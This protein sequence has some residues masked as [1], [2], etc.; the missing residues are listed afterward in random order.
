M[1]T[2]T[3]WRRIS[4][5]PDPAVAALL[6]ALALLP[7]LWTSRGQVSADTKTYLT[8]DP[9]D[10]LASASSMWDPSV[11]AGTVPHQNIG[12][13]FPLGPYYWLLDAIGSPD[14]LA[15]RLLWGVLVF[16]ASYGTYRLLRWLGWAPTGS[17]VAAVAYGFSPYLLSYLAR[18]SAILFPWAALPWMVLLA[19]QAARDH[20]WRRAAQF[21]VVV[22]LVGSVNATSL[23]FVGL[24]PVLWLIAD[25][26][27]GRIATRAVAAAA[28]RIGVLSAAVSVWWVSGLRVQGIY[29]LPILDFTE[30]YQTVASASTA[31]EVLRGLG[32]WFFYGGDVLDPWVGPA[33]P[34]FNDP[35]VMFLSFGLAGCALLGLLTPFRGRA[36]MLLLFGVGLVL[37]VGAAPLGDSTWY[38]SWFQHFATESTAGAALRSTPRAAPLVLLALACGL[39]AGTTALQR[40]MASGAIPALRRCA[41]ALPAVATIAVLVN[42]LP[43][44]T[45]NVT[46]AAL[47]RPEELPAS[48]TELADYVNRSDGPTGRIYAIPGS[49]FADYQWGGTVDPVLPGLTDRSVLYRELIPQGGPGT[50]DLLNAFERRLFEGWFE[51]ATL[52]TIAHLFAVDTIVVRNDLQHERYRL[53][54]PG[55]LWT[56][57]TAVLGEADYDGVLVEDRSSAALTDEIAL[58]R[59]DAATSFPINAA[60]DVQTGDALM[61]R[62]ASTPMI[63]AGSGDGLVDLA[64]AGLLDPSSAVLYAAAL[65]NAALAAAESPWW[66][67]TDTNR[68]QAHRWSTLGFNLGAIESVSALQSDDDPGDSRLELFDD[69]LVD[70][71]IAVH[72]GDVADVSATSYGSDIVYITEDAPQFGADGDLSTA[73]RGAIAAPSTGLGYHVEFA[74]AELLSHLTLV[75]PQVGVNDRFITR[76]RV[77]TAAG[78]FDVDLTEDSR[79]SQG[80]RIDV[81]GQP[82]RT[83]KVSIEILAD[84]IGDIATYVGQPGVGFAEVTPVRTDGAPVID[85]RVVRL[86]VAS[87]RGIQ[88]DDRLTYVFTRQRFDPA[89]SNRQA[90]ERALDR[91]FDVTSSRSFEMIGQAR[92]SSNASDAVLATL[93]TTNSENTAITAIASTRLPGSV[94][95]RGAAAVDGDTATAWQTPFDGAEGAALTLSQ[96]AG[97]DFDELTLSWWDDGRH[98]VPTSITVTDAIDDDVTVSVPA[99]APVDGVA[100]TT[101]QLPPQSGDDVVITISGVSAAT[102]PDF[103]SGVPRQLP[104]AIAE[105]QFGGNGAAPPLATEVSTGCR[106]DLLALDGSALSVEIS[107]AVDGVLTLAGCDG[108]LDLAPGDHRLTATRGALTGVDIDR[109]VFDDAETGSGSDPIQQSTLPSVGISSRAATAI[110][111]TLPATTAATWLVLSQS[112]NLGWTLA[113]DGQDMGEPQLINGYAN[114]WLLDAG[115]DGR[116]VELRWTPQQ[117]VNIALW[118]S[119]AAGVGILGLLAVTARRRRADADPDEATDPDGSQ[120]ATVPLGRTAQRFIGVGLVA[121]FLVVGGYAAGVAAAAVVLTRHIR[122]LDRWSGRAATALVCV[123]WG[124]VSGLI[125]ASEWRYDYAGG[126]DWPLQF[127]WAS[128]ITWAVVATVVTA[129]MMSVIAAHRRSPPF[130]KAPAR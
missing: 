92:L 107:G 7:M 36:S 121:G 24:A 65:D 39:G 61:L 84:N 29:G 19:A 108:P 60:F 94:A 91:Q 12:Y 120:T 15:Q 115:V 47:L 102:V 114:G 55:P 104:I 51:P 43:W 64:A 113:I 58:A 18:L 5:R 23:V 38:G 110:D 57:V 130:A 128:P 54:R 72:L 10:L 79:T 22:A 14:W 125:I 25:A 1:A 42:L 126:P 123:G 63:V 86:P 111:A 88:P 59:T 62:D 129:A 81:G 101:L 21:A 74:Q 112:H 71:T 13:L 76:V 11:G 95:S 34:Y 46:S 89:T 90:S 30:T 17:L 49:D 93:A 37:S 68:K 16:A 78:S 117:S 52:P 87:G 124:L 99:V 70:Q 32:Y 83:S 103:Y 80:Q 27:S 41:P 98:G 31:P 56:D 69:K 53:A 33:A 77:T 109:L 100:T 3:L 4:A 20:S 6:A 118:F 50:A 9:G 40:R 66:V 119:L 45:G 28:L 85:D 105:V 48:T 73:W 97:F 127:A 122:A 82:Q 116:A 2:S 75:Q 26:A 8:L 96:P 44:F 67:M 35:V 106:D